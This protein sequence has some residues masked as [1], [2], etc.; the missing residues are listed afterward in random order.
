[1][2][3]KMT[4][5]LHFLREE[6]HYA[7]NTI[8]AYQSDLAQFIR[9]AEGWGTASDKQWSD[10]SVEMV[11]AYIDSLYR[12]AYAAS[13]VVRKIATIKSILN[14]LQAPGGGRSSLA[15]KLAKLSLVKHQPKS[16]S[17]DE[18]ERLLS[19]PCQHKP[20]S[21][22]SLR[23]SALLNLL[24]ATGM[25]V[26]E[27]VMLSVSSLHL[28]DCYVTCGEGDRQVR[29][30]PLPVST[31]AILRR[32]LAEGR[33]CLVRDTSQC[34]LFVNHR[35]QK[36]TRQG[37]WLIIKA[38][39]EAAGLGD[40]VTPHTLRHS[41]AMHR[42][43]QGADLRELQQLLG[44]ASI[45]TTQVYARQTAE[46]EAATAPPPPTASRRTKTP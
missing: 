26:T 29:R 46:A 27:A 18:V 8:A 15:K 2:R 14:Y 19:M 20:E 3:A 25:R 1:M 16:L 7:D 23:D 36:L 34:A 33:G 45:S 22:R 30:I 44:H 39:A 24:Y 37:L 6:Q 11:D 12:E 21:A 35:G 9:F 43:Q 31:V 41:F 4:S 5:F 32:Y 13:T 38:Y 42:L 40:S 10:V 17:R 28:D